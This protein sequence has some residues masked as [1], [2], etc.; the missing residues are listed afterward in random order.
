MREYRYM[1]IPGTLCKG[2]RRAAR[3][4]AHSAAEYEGL[5]D[6]VMSHYADLVYMLRYESVDVRCLM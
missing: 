4:S 5:F 2:V 1:Y 6:F 3:V